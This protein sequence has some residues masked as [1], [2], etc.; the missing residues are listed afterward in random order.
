MT[1]DARRNAR[2][3]VGKQRTSSLKGS[4]QVG[5]HFSIF[6]QNELQA[7]R[8]YYTDLLRS[9]TFSI[10]QIVIKHSVYHDRFK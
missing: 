7:Q 3:P 9:V 2:L 1:V 6:L 5:C 10:Q 4:S 8:K